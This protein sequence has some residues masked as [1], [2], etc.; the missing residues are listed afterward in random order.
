MA[1]HDGPGTRADELYER[2]RSDIFMGRLKPGQRLKFPQLC[3]DYGTSVGPAREALTKLT[4]ERLVTLQAHQ[5]YAVASLSVAELTDLTAARVE[6][7]TLAFRQ[8]MLNGDDRWESEVVASHH[9]LARR[10]RQAIDGGRDDSWYLAHEDF[11]AA[12]L[13][14]CGNRRIVEMAQ[15]L[16]AEAE[17]YRRWAAPFIEENDRNPAAEHKALADAAIERDVERGVE[18]LRDHIAFTTQMLLGSLVAL[19]A[20]VE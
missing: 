6:L 15:G 10:E 19:D 17:L 13:A 5:G 4:A 1:K 2:L 7:E 9:L 20:V 11:H 14:G 12:L 3:A 18:L 8:A 16:R